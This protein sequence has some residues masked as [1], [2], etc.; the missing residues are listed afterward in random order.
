MRGERGRGGEKWGAGQAVGVC[1]ALQGQGSPGRW[2]RGVKSFSIELQE[3]P[4]SWLRGTQPQ[5]RQGLDRS[6]TGRQAERKGRGAP[7]SAL[8]SPVTQAD[9]VERSMNVKLKSVHGV[10]HVP[11]PKRCTG[12]KAAPGQKGL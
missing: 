9:H 1:G 8:E 10:G 7:P 6:A 3:E 12:T 4:E 11:L 5:R 2:A